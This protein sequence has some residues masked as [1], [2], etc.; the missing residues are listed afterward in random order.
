MERQNAELPAPQTHQRGRNGGLCHSSPSPQP[1]RL[2]VAMKEVAREWAAQG[3]KPS[4]IRT[5]I[6][7]RFNLDETSLPSLSKVQC[8]AHN[9]AANHLRNN[10]VLLALRA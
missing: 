10:D 9:Y 7:R 8:F 3:L 2:T 1:P 6:L 4:R 5:G